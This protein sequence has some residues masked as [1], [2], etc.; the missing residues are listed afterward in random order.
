MKLYAYLLKHKNKW[1]SELG[2]VWINSHVM[3][4]QLNYPFNIITNL[5]YLLVKQFTF[6]TKRYISFKCQ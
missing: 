4:W 5:K 3:I 2:I 6:N 1:L